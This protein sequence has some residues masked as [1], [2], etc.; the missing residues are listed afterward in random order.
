MDNMK[1]EIIACEKRL[2]DAMKNSNMAVLD[3]LL[4]DDLLFNA[5]T[6][7]VIDKR[8]DLAAYESGNMIIKDLAIIEQEIRIFENV[9][10]VSVLLN[11][12]GDFMGSTIEGKVRFFR[13][14]KRINGDWKMIGGSSVNVN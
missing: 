5:A 10:I 14:W 1:D 6:G 2:M 13:T 3:E 7:Q 4:H 11:L 9:A 8:M 12:K